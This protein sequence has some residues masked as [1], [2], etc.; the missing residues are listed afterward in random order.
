MTFG[1]LQIS[2]QIANWLF[3]EHGYRACE[4]EGEP[5]TLYRPFVNVYFGVAYLRWLSNFE[6]RTRGEEFV[7]RAFKGGTKK[8]NHKSTLSYWKRYIAIKESLPSRFY[9][10]CFVPRNVDQLVILGRS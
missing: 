8:A 5:S 7:V 10:Y 4:L 2:S 1:I 3:R 6:H 9:L